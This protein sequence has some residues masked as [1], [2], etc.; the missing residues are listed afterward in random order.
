MQHFTWPLL[1][2]AMVRI[3]TAT[4]LSQ[5]KQL[6]SLEGQLTVV[7]LPHDSGSVPTN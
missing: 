3:Q 4:L 6:N 1:L 5:I 7:M 2:K